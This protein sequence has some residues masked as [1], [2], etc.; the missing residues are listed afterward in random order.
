MSFNRESF[1]SSR[2]EPR[3]AGVRIKK[4]DLQGF[5]E[6]EEEPVWTVRGLTGEELGKALEASSNLEKVQEAVSTLMSNNSQEIADSVK[7]LFNKERPED[8]VKRLEFLV[9]GSVDPECD[10]QMAVKV[11]KNFP[12]EFFDLTNK[13][14]NLT[15]L[16][17]SIAKKKPSGETQK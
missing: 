7:T 8:I 17:H 4:S 13:I 6:G 15:G 10:L 14:R 3:T 2:F 11:C 5:F 9:M 1:M 12:V 16:G